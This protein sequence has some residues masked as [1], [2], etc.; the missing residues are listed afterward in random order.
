MD[1]DPELEVLDLQG[2]ELGKKGAQRL[3]LKGH[4]NELA[5]L[6]R[7]LLTHGCLKELNL[8]GLIELDRPLPDLHSMP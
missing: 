4:Y 7:A 6:A 3:G 5:R 8:V 2:E 1:L